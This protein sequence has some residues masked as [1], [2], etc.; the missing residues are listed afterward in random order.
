ML[1]VSAAKETVRSRI[2][3]VDSSFAQMSFD[4]GEF[5]REGARS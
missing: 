1:P 4:R 2:G 3:Y 5:V